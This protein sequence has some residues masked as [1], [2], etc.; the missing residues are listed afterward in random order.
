MARKLTRFLSVGLMLVMILS[1]MVGVAD[2]QET[3]MVIGWEQ[4]PP[5]L[6]P[7]VNMVFSIALEEFYARDVWNWDHDRNIYPV[8][9]AEIPTVENGMVETNDEG[10][11]V[12]TVRLRE[13]MK[14]SDGEPI[15]AADCAFWHEIMMNPELAPNV[16]RGNYPNVVESFEVID[17]YTYQI[18][19]NQPWPDY[20]SDSYGRC[21]YPE[22]VLRPILEAEGSITNAPQWTGQGVVGYGPYVL[23]EWVLGDT[24]TF[25]R[26]PNWDG[27]PPAIDRVIIKQI[28]DASQMVSAMEAGEIDLA[29]FFSDDLVDDYAAIPDVVTWSEPGV[30]SDA[31]WINM[32]EN[33]HPALHDVNVRKALVHALDRRTMADGLVSPNVPIPNSWWFPQFNPPDLAVWDYNPDL[34]N[35]LLDEAG[36]VDT[37]D[38]GIRDKNGGELILRF[39]T[40]TRQIRMDYQLLMQEYWNAVGIGTQVLPVPAGILFDTFSNR[41]ILLTYDYDIA[42]YGLTADPLTPNSEAAFNC[43]QVASPEQPDG[44]NYVGFCNEEYD[45]LDALVNTTLDP[46]ERLQYHY[47][48]ERIINEAVFYIGL[49][50]RQTNYALNAERFD[51]ESV[52]GLGTLSFNFFEYVENW[53]PAA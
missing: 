14:W 33:A 15:T 38:N 53:Q 49:Y 37:N 6:Y 36:W 3:V 30:T 18:T 21:S 32:T 16:P 24:I 27:Q 25:D 44:H 42:L 13:G 11:T 19:Y 2:A 39:Y 48:A 8:M 46:E 29:W 41:G 45:R 43:D 17:D 7:M 9:A 31:L 50:V 5:Q 12:V 40:T 34:A 35:Q 23:T 10:N 28:P 47:E 20:Q 4:E 26:N 1:L 51:P 52:M 22:H